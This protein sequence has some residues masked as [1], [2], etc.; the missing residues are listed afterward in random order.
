MPVHRSLAEHTVKPHGVQY[1]FDQTGM[2]VI[3][4]PDPNQ[5]DDDVNE[6]F[7]DTDISQQT[8]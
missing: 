5:L 3:T 1:L 6:E 8:A 2:V 4:L 7:E